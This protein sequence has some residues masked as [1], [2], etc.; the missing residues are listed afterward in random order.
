MDRRAVGRRRH[1]QAMRE[2]RC[3]LGGVPGWLRRGLLAG[4][5]SWR[6]RCAGALEFFFVERSKGFGRPTV[7]TVRVGDD[8]LRPTAREDKG[9][10]AAVRSSRTVSQVCRPRIPYLPV[11]SSAHAV[12]LKRMKRADGLVHSGAPE[13]PLGRPG[14]SVGCPRRLRPL[15]DRRARRRPHELL[16]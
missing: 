5:C 16:A 15:G 2:R 11:R 9:S 12:A 10:E 13:A 8:G 4:L 7:S 14:H 1:K 3:H 6:E